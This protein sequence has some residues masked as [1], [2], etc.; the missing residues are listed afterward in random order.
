MVSTRSRTV[1]LRVRTLDP[2]IEQIVV[3]DVGDSADGI[4]QIQIWPLLIVSCAP[5]GQRLAHDGLPTEFV[6]RG[7][8]SHS[9]RWTKNR[10]ETADD[11]FKTTVVQRAKQ[12]LFLEF[13]RRIR[14]L[15]LQILR[16]AIFRNCIELSAVHSG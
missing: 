6:Y 10:A 2:P 16:R 12:V 9:G 3:D 5:D 8:E 11:R 1:A 4:A 14:A 13:A 7:V 15:R